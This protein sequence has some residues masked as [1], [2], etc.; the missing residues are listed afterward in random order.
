MNC[1]RILEREKEYLANY[2]EF[3]CDR[4]SRCSHES[5]KPTEGEE[6]VEEGVVKYEF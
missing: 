4:F 3:N 1:W 6:V 2:L 5:L